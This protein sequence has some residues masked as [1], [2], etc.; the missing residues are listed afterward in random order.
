MGLVIAKRLIELMGGAIGFDSAPG[1]G[2]HFWFVV[3]LE[4]QDGGIA[5]CRRQGFQRPRVL[6]VEGNGASRKAL[7]RQLAAWNA[8]VHAVPDGAAALGRRDR[9]E[10]ERTIP[11]RSTRP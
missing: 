8:T 10:G 1:I 4:R 2:S 6:L 9:S 3:T 11:L 7:A 5:G